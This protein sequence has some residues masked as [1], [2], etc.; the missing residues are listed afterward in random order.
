MRWIAA[1]AAGALGPVG[2]LAAAAAPAQRPITQADSGKT[3]LITRGGHRTLRL[4]NRWLWSDPRPSSKAVELTPVEYL[5]GPGFREW[6]IA[7]R[8]LGK[9]TI[10]ASGKPNCA[11]C[12]ARRF[13]VT[14]DVGAR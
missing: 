7:A 12:T 11:S 5:V 13:R 9:A 2:V 6:R 14:I 8:A 1:L 3:F 4:S 10:R